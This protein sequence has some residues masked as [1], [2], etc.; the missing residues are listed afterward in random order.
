MLCFFVT[1]SF[2]VVYVPLITFFIFFLSLAAAARADDM[3]LSCSDH[4]LACLC[5]YAP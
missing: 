1:E 5:F 2:V 3:C 4:S